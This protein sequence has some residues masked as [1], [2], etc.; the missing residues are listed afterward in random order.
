MPLRKGVTAEIA[1]ELKA[2]EMAEDVYLSERVTCHT[3]KGLMMYTPPPNTALP[4]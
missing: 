4:I 2:K 1:T 3:K